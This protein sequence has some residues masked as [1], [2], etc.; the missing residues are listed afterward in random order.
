QLFF[1]E[2][3]KTGTISYRVRQILK[4]GSTVYSNII[5]FSTPSN[6][7][8]SVYTNP[9]T[10][11]FMINNITTENKVNVTLYDLTGKAVRTIAYDQ[12]TKVSLQGI[13]PG[14]YTI[15]VSDNDQFNASA[16]LIVK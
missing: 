3:A 5:T 1:S 4:N 14:I 15:K 8:I 9:T 11:Y 7:N 13:Q 10:D 16:R 6:I 2:K 12:N